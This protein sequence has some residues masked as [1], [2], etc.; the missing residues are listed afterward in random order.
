M[1][2]VPSQYHNTTVDCVPCSNSEY[3]VSKNNVHAWACEICVDNI[4][5]ASLFRLLLTCRQLFVSKTITMDSFAGQTLFRNLDRGKGLGCGHRAVCHPSRWSAY[6]SQ[7]SILSHATIA[8]YSPTCN[9]AELC[10]LT[11]EVN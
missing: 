9:P 3:L 7:R 10:D 5:M 4:G 1:D 8:Q 6:Q 11:G 2:C